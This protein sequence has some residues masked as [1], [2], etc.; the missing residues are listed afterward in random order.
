MSNRKLIYVTGY[1]GAPIRE[2]AHRI[3]AC[4]GWSVLNLN[5]SIE[6]KDGRS[7]ARICMMGGEHAYRNAEYEMVAALCEGGWVEE[8]NLCSDDRAVEVIPCPD[9][10]EVEIVMCS[11]GQTEEKVLCPD[12]R[13]KEAQGQSTAVEA[14]VGAE[15][16][17]GDAA[18]LVVACGDGILYDE[19]SRDLIL[20]HELVIAG[21]TLSV[22]QLWENARQDED[23]YHAFMKFGSEE[24]KRIKFEEQHRRQAILFEKIRES[25]NRK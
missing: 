9:S 4:K 19:D 1:F 18:G 15:D 2:E 23:T 16:P 3:A 7:I 5:R 12:G 25:G 13:T 8:K 14:G 22:E 11:D 6:A 20:R 10:Q 24:E 17:I 21:E